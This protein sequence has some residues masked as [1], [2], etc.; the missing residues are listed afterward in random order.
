VSEVAKEIGKRA[1]FL[2]DLPMPAGGAKDASVLFRFSP[3]G[4]HPFSIFT[5]AAGAMAAGSSVAT[6]VGAAG[7]SSSAAVA[8]DAALA[9]P[10]GSPT[11]QGA[12]GDFVRGSASN[13]FLTIV[14][15][16]TSEP[17]KIPV[18]SAVGADASATAVGTAD[19]SLTGSWAGASSL[20]AAPLAD[21]AASERV[22]L[23][24]DVAD[25]ASGLWLSQ[26]QALLARS[27]V[28]VFPD[29]GASS[30]SVTSVAAERV[31]DLAA[32]EE[33]K[34]LVAGAEVLD[35]VLSHVAVT[36]RAAVAASA[37]ANHLRRAV[38]LRHGN[39]DPALLDRVQRRLKELFPNVAVT[40]ADAKVNAA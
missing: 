34:S 24:P 39:T 35:A 9:N 4:F 2:K 36:G 23:L 26:V 29:A 21:A 17:G 18:V 3:T 8:V 14:P 27:A 19:L 22:L 33:C 37:L 40:V 25:V 20:P 16:A 7:G 13:P 38:V 10:T 5:L 15:K 6:Q 12:A 31:L 1:A 11:S 30:S 28:A 32:E